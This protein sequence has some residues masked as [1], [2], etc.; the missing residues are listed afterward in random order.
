MS[1]NNPSPAQRAQME[2]AALRT[3]QIVD[4]AGNNLGADPAQQPVDDA[5]TDPN[6][7]ARP[8]ERDADEDAD[9]GTARRK[10]IFMS[11]ADE[12]RLAIAKRFTHRDP[13]GEVPFN[14]NGADPEM[15][16]GRA[17]REV[18]PEPELDEI[19]QEEEDQP[20]PAPRAQE[21]LFTIKVRGKDIHLT[22][23]QLLER[24]SKVEAADQYLDEG[25][26]LLEQARDARRNSAERTGED[27]HRP[28]DRTRTHDDE[29]DPP[30]TEHGQRPDPLEQAIEEIQFGDPKE[31]AA[32]IRKA[33][34]ETSDE[35]ADKRQLMRLERADGLAS[36]KAVMAFKKNNPTLDNPKTER[37]IESELYDL[38][39]EEIVKLGQVD[40]DKIPNDSTQLAKWHQ[41]YRIHGA[42]VSS[43][44]TL[45]DAAKTRFEQWRGVAPKPQQPRKAAPRIEVN[46]DRN[47]RRQ[48][49]PSQPSRASAPRPDASQ[50]VPQMDRRAQ[51]ILNMRRA[52]GQLV[53]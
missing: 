29:L 52:R 38:Q 14:G 18:E 17:G 46:V 20:E 9:Q 6:P 39:R 4:D 10:T 5:T 34:A 37:W 31:A 32:K 7:P 30:A 43:Q 21:R 51:A 28:E 13:E 33:I 1:T 53:G 27:P 8:I 24:A 42:A 16:Y 19:E 22:E 47:E 49:I 12:A 15:R 3:T 44:E 23:A 35:S 26:N 2:E 50:P 45:L 11:P 25:R 41:F 48:N 40:P 36:A